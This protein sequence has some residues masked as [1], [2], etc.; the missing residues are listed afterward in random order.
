MEVDRR[1]QCI[2]EA[3]VCANSAPLDAAVH[4]MLVSATASAPLTPLSVTFPPVIG[5][6]FFMQG[7]I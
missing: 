2:D 3:F 5:R 6:G 1:T 4:N 7:T